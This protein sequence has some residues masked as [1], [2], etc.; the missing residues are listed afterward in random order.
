MSFEF[1]PLENT[2]RS[3]DGKDPQE[4]ESLGGEGGLFGRVPGK[5][6]VGATNSRFVGQLI[7]KL[8]ILRQQDFALRFSFS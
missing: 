5:P 2:D 7:H 1:D 8:V 3:E 6:Q 4:I